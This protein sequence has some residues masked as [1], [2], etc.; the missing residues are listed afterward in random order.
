MPD[1]LTPEDRE[2]L[3]SFQE[4]ADSAKDGPP[5]APP[6]RFG[7]PV[8]LDEEGREFTFGPDQDQTAEN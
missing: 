4:F 1:E 2:A 8:G 7:Y 5:I 6:E 3:A